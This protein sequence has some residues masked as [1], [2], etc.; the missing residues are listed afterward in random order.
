MMAQALFSVVIK[1]GLQTKIAKYSWSLEMEEGG[2]GGWVE[3]ESK[4]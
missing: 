1:M 4:G 2:R 3:R